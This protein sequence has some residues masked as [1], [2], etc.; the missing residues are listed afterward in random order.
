MK[1]FARLLLLIALLAPLSAE[2]ASRFWVGGTGT[3]DASDTTHWAATS[4]GAGGQS[5]PGSGDTA[6]FDGSSGG[7]TVTVSTAVNIQSITCGAFTGTINFGANNVTLSTAT[8]FNCSGTGTRTINLGSGIWT[9][10]GSSSTPWTLATT[11]GLTFNA[12]TTTINFTGAASGAGT[13]SIQGGGQTYNVVSFQA[14]VGI[15]LVG[16]NTFATLDITGPNT[17]YI[18]NGSTQTVTNPLNISGTG[19][20]PIT[21][22]STSSA[23]TTAISSAS[24]G[25]FSYTAFRNIAFSGGG[26][27]TANNSF[28][29]NGNSGITINPPSAGGGGIIGGN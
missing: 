7:G 3:W 29:L 15:N 10:Q 11:T 13:I 2:A 26:T 14:N 18:T 20:D 22:I 8:G 19:A 23:A 21:L 28:D 5:V 27:F 16:N 6:T 24:N 1:I 4:G 25:T 17:I 9:L 12:G